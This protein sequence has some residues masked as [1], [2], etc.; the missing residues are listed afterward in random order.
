MIKAKSENVTS[1]EH[2]ID[3][4]PKET[5]KPT[6]QPKEI[7]EEYSQNFTEEEKIQS[8]YTVGSDTSSY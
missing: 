1:K 2:K 8:E 4:H 3:F 5:K 6:P 7:T